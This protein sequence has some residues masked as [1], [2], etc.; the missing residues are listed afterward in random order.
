M[1]TISTL[2]MKIN[3]HGRWIG[4]ALLLAVLAGAWAGFDQL[5]P[6]VPGGLRS[7]QSRLGWYLRSGQWHADVRTAIAAADYVFDPAN[8]L[9]PTVPSATHHQMAA[10]SSPPLPS[11]G[12]DGAHDGDPS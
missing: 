2:R 7:G 5:M 9:L 8:D 12:A 11:A 10:A 6:Q 3:H 1:K 4:G